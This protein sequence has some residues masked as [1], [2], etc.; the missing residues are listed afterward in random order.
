MLLS[1]KRFI[2]L[3][4]TKGTLIPGSLVRLSART[5]P[6][7]RDGFSVRIPPFRVLLPGKRAILPGK[8]FYWQKR[9]FNFRQECCAA[10]QPI[11][12]TRQARGSISSQE[13]SIIRQAASISA[14]LVQALRAVW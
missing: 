5:V 9:G 8:K 11:D 3:K 1:G 14:Q 13:A 12:F 10:S 6:S 4:P 7:R 2:A